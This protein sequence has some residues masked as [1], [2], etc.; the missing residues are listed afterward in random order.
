MDIMVEKPARSKNATILWVMLAIFILVGTGILALGCLE[1]QRYLAIE[2]NAVTVQAEGYKIVDVDDDGDNDFR[3][4]VRYTYEGEVYS[5]IYKTYDLQRDA[6]KLMG[7]WVD[8][9]INPENPSEQ[10]NDIGTGAR[11]L[12][13]MGPFFLANG[14]GFVFCRKRKCYTEVYGWRREYIQMDLD[15][16]LLEDCGLW[17]GFLSAGLLYLGLWRVFPSAMGDIWIISFVA[18]TIGILILLGW[19]SKCHKI[20]EEKYRLSRQTMTDKKIDDSGDST[21]Y[22]LY[23]SNGINS[24]HRSV[25]RKRFDSAQIGETVEAVFLDGTKR[26]YFVYD[27]R[28]ET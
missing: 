5:G 22:N 16:K 25:S 15:R 19:L 9:Q 14:I 2:K 18:C 28:D 1:G 23:Y 20:R 24:W 26:P 7:Q 6:E 17:A 27:C 4:Y 3:L 21:S 11:F 13:L 12:C 8:V 10:L